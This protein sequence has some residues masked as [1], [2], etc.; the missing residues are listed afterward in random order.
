LHDAGEVAQFVCQ[1]LSLPWDEGEGDS[2]APAASEESFFAIVGDDGIRLCQLM[3]RLE[4]QGKCV[5]QTELDTRTAVYITTL[6][7]VNL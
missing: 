3:E 7:N 4:Q 2:A 5:P 1:Q 6:K